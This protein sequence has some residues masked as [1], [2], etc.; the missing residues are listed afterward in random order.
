M[1]RYPFAA[2]TVAALLAAPAIAQPSK[3]AIEPA[4]PDA[5]P[6]ATPAQPTTAPAAS[7]GAGNPHVPGHHERR[8]VA[9]RHRLDGT[10]AAARRADVRVSGDSISAVEPSLQPL[11][12]ERVIDAAGHVV[13]PGFIDIHTHSDR[14]LLADGLAQSALRQGA[15]THVIGNCGSSPAPVS[16]PAAGKKAFRTY[17]EF[18]E[19]LTASGVSVAG[20]DSMMAAMSVCIWATSSAASPTWPVIA[21]SCSIWV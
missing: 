21:P 1:P 11:P 12:G 19:A 14:T 13:A 4:K 18:L 8:H 9:E 15:T 17:G 6:A 10:G 20:T 2:L 16:E 3:K 5:A 7:L